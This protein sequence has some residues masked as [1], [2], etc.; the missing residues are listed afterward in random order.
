M[1]DAGKAALHLR[2]LLEDM[3]FSQAQ[4]MEIQADTRGALQMMNA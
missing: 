2:P 3:G 4:P 1:A